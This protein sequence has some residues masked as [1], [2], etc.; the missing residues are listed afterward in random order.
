[1]TGFSP[2]FE[3]DSILGFKAHSQSDLQAAKPIAKVL[4][5]AKV[6]EEEKLETSKNESSW[7]E[8]GHPLGDEVGGKSISDLGLS[9]LLRFGG[10]GPFGG[11]LK[12]RVDVD[13]IGPDPL[14]FMS[15]FLEELV[16]DDELLGQWGLEKSE[17]ERLSSG[18]EGSKEIAERL[19]KIK[20]A[21]E[22]NRPEAIA[23]FSEELKDQL[24]IKGVVYFPVLDEE[25]KYTQVV[26]VDKEHGFSVIEVDAKHSPYLTEA[27]QL[28]QLSD[29]GKRQQLIKQTSIDPI[30]GKKTEVFKVQQFMSF[31][32]R[33][34][35][36]LGDKEFFAELVKNSVLESENTREMIYTSLP[37]YVDGKQLKASDTE[38]AFYRK[39]YRYFDKDEK[40]TSFQC[41]SALLYYM[42]L[43]PFF[44]SE[45]DCEKAVKQYKTIKFLLQSQ[46]FFAYV[47]KIED[48]EKWNKVSVE[49]RAFLNDLLSNLTRSAEKLLRT[50]AI[51]KEQ[52]NQFFISGQHV[53]DVL[54]SPI[55]AQGI[56][57]FEEQEVLARGEVLSSLTARFDD[58]ETV[59]AI[60]IPP[61]A[62]VGH[63]AGGLHMPAAQDAVDEKTPAQ[64]LIRELTEFDYTL[65]LT[66]ESEDKDKVID[67]LNEN[68]E[69]LTEQYK[70]L[71]ANPR[72]SHTKS[73]FHFAQ[74]A[75]ESERRAVFDQFNRTLG[76]VVAMLP[77]PE[78]G[79]NGFWGKLTPDQA[80]KCFEVVEGFSLLVQSFATLER[81][82][83]PFARHES[84]S[85]H[86][87]ETT[88][89]M[90]T[91]QAVQ[92]KLAS[93]DPRFALEEGKFSFLPYLIEMRSIGFVVEHPG[94]R[95]QVHSLMRY[96]NPKWN[97]EELTRPLK[98][99][100]LTEDI[101][102]LFSFSHKRE[103]NAS[104]WEISLTND[105]KEKSLDQLYFEKMLEASDVRDGVRE[106]MTEKNAEY[107]RQH[108][109]AVERYE[110]ELRQ[111]KDEKARLNELIEE[112]KIEIDT[113]K[114]RHDPLINNIAQERDRQRLRDLYSVNAQIRNAHYWDDTT[115]LKARKAQ[116]LQNLS[117]IPNAED[118]AE[119]LHQAEEAKRYEL[120][121]P[122]RRLND[123]QFD[124]NRLA[125]PNE[126]VHPGN[127]PLDSVV[128]Q[129]SCLLF[130]EEGRRL[131]PKEMNALVQAMMRNRYLILNDTVNFDLDG[132]EIGF[133]FTGGWQP[134]P[135]DAQNKRGSITCS[136]E[137]LELDRG[138]RSEIR[139]DFLYDCS[140]Y[141]IGNLR[142]RPAFRDNDWRLEDDYQTLIRIESDRELTQNQAMISRESLFGL[143]VSLTKEL[144]MLAI[145]PYDVVSR[146]VGFLR[147]NMELI[148]NP[149]IQ[150]YVHVLLFRP[151]RIHTQLRDNP[152][153]T[154]KIDAFIRAA[155]THYKELHD[156]DTCLAMI[157]LG[158]QFRQAAVEIN[159]NSSGFSDYRKVVLK[160]LIPSFSS[161]KATD[162][163]AQLKAYRTLFLLHAYDKSSSD[164]D[165]KQISKIVS[166]LLALRVC[167]NL[168]SE[169]AMVSREDESLEK[170]ALLRFQ[171]LLEKEIS[172]QDLTNA[173]KVAVPDAGLDDSSEWIDNGDGT[174]TCGMFEINVN[175]GLVKNDG[176]DVVTTPDWI[177]DNEMLRR[178]YPHSFT[179]STCQKVN[180]WT[181]VLFP[182]EEDKQV[183]VTSN[184]YGRTVQI[185]RL[186]G[187]KAYRFV[188]TPEN[189][190]EYMPTLFSRDVLCWVDDRSEMLVYKDN[191]KAY[192]V[193]YEQI[194]AYQVRVEAL[195]RLSDLATHVS[196]LDGPLSQYFMPL[197]S[198]EKDPK[199]IECWQSRDGKKITV[200]F[201]RLGLSFDIKP[202]EIEK[203][204]LSRD[205][206]LKT[207]RMAELERLI[208]ET[209]E[210]DEVRAYQIEHTRLR[211]ELA[212]MFPVHCQN[213]PGFSL[214]MPILT[215]SL[216]QNVPYITLINGSGER[217]ILVPKTENQSERVVEQPMEWYEYDVV[218][219]KSNGATSFDIK[220]SSVEL[221][222]LQLTMLANRRD[223]KKVKEILDKLNPLGALTENE[224]RL[225]E[226]AAGILGSYNHPEANALVVK[227]LLVREVNSLK[228]PQ[229]RLAEEEAE[230]E[231][232][233]DNLEEFFRE[234]LLF[235]GA[236]ER[237][238]ANTGDLAAFRLTDEEERKFVELLHT[239]LKVKF[240]KLKNISNREVDGAGVLQ[241]IGAKAQQW[242][243][244]QMLPTLVAGFLEEK[245][246]DRFHDLS[247]QEGKLGF[248]KVT[249]ASIPRMDQLQGKGA[250]PTP[251]EEEILRP[252][253]EILGEDGTR[254][255]IP[256]ARTIDKCLGV[257]VKDEAYWKQ[258]FV[259]LY[260]VARSGTDDEKSR[261]Q[262]ALDLATHLNSGEHRILRWVMDKPGRYKS[263]EQLNEIIHQWRETALKELHD[264][265]VDFDVK[266][267]TLDRAQQD[268][269]LKKQRYEDIKSDEG[270]ILDGAEFCREASRS[271]GL[272]ERIG[273]LFRYLVSRPTKSRRE[274]Y[275]L[276]ER[277]RVLNKCKKLAE[278][279]KRTAENHL[280]NGDD[281]WMANWYRSDVAK[282][283]R[284]I[285]DIERR[286]EGIREISPE[287]ER[288]KNEL[289]TS[290]KA[291]SKAESE[292]V[293]ANKRREKAAR[294]VESMEE[295][296]K[297]SI[298]SVL[299]GKLWK[300]INNFVKPIF[301]AIG[302]VWKYFW[303]GKK[304]LNSH[305]YKVR[306]IFSSGLIT[307]TK[308]PLK[309]NRDELCAVDQSFN[310]YFQELADHFFDVT[311]TDEGEDPVWNATDGGD[312]L[313]K[314]KLDAEKNALNEYRED[315]RKVREHADLKEDADI[316]DLLEELVEK[317][318]TLKA[319]LVHQKE[320]LLW[321]LNRAINSNEQAK[322]T[323]SMNRIGMKGDL[324]WD[325]LRALSL[326]GDLVDFQ[327]KTGLDETNAKMLMKGVADYLVKATRLNQIR[328][329]I[330]KV[331][332]A[333]AA[334]TEDK[335]KIYYTNILEALKLERH[336]L[337]DS[338][339]TLS[340]K[341]MGR[342]WFE[343]SNG[344]LY[345]E[346]QIK[347]L[348]ETG[349]MTDPEIL[350]EAPTGFGKSKNY[351][352]TRDHEMAGEHLVLNVH[353]R[354]IEQIN[355]E[356]ILAQMRDSFGG[357]ADRFHFQRSTQFTVH[358]LKALYED[359]QVNFE[360]GR[361][362]NFSAETL[363]AL[364]LHFLMYLYDYK[365][366]EKSGTF[367]E[368]E[369]TEARQEIAYFIMIL[370]AVS[371]YGWATIDESHVNLNPFTNKLIY[372]IGES[373]TL[374]TYQVDILEEMMRLMVDDTEIRRIAKVE[375]NKQ[376]KV[377]GD[378]Y[379]VIARKLGNHFADK[380]RIEEDKKDEYLQFVLGNLDE[381]PGWIQKHSQAKQIALVKG[382]LS[383]ILK[384]SM[385]GYVDETYGLSKLHFDKGKEYAIAY[386]SSNTPK[387]NETSPSQFKNPHETMAKTYLT[388]LHKGLREEQVVKMIKKMQA[389]QLL[390]AQTTGS[391]SD[392][393]ANKAFREIAGEEYS[394]QQLNEEDMHRLFPAFQHNADAIF[395]YVRNI[396][397]PQLRLYEKTLVSTP[398]NLRS[399]FGSSLSL[400]A[401]PQDPATHGP[402]TVMVPMKGTQG[403]VTHLFLKK[404]DRSEKIHKAKGSDPEEVME[405]AIDTV[406]INGHIKCIID[407][408][409]LMR[410]L[411]N[412]KVA[413]RLRERILESDSSIEAV[414]YFD[415]VKE[416]F[417]VMEVSTGTLSD[418]HVVKT[419]PAKMVTIFDQPRCFGSDTVQDET[420]SALLLVNNSKT[421]SCNTDKNKAGQG[422][423][424][425]RQWHL[426]QGMEVMMTP[427]DHHSLFGDKEAN[428]GDLLNEWVGSLAKQEAKENYQALLQQMDNELRSPAMHRMLGVK[429]GD[430]EKAQK[431]TIRDVVPDVDKALR[432]FGK[433]ESLLVTDDSTD[434]W[435]LYA[436]MPK[437][438]KPEECLD[439]HLKRTKAKA[440]KMGGFSSS[441]RKILSSRLGR[442]SK[443][444]EK[445]E[446]GA[447]D[448]RVKLPELVQS[449][450]VDTGNQV[451]VQVQAEQEVEAHVQEQRIDHLK[452]RTPSKW[453]DRISLFDSGW[454]KPRSKSVFFNRLAN[455]ISKLEP[456]KPILKVA[457]RIGL[458]AAGTAL[459]ATVA[460]VA[461]VAWPI[462]VGVGSA[463]L[464]VGSFYAVYKM[465]ARRNVKYMP[466]CSYKVSEVM[467][468]HLPKRAKRAARFF[469]P[470]LTVS[471]NYYA[472]NTPSWRESVQKPFNQEQK[473]VFNVLVIQ[474]KDAEGKKKLQMMMI[475]QNDSVYF[476]RRLQA[477]YEQAGQEDAEKR[478]RKIAVY[479]VVNGVISVEGAN[480][481][482]ERELEDNPEF[483]SLLMQ[484]KVINGEIHYT[485]EEKAALGKRA[486]QV[487]VAQMTRFAE[488]YALA[489][490]PIQKLLFPDS[491]FNHALQ[492]VMV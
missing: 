230:E 281:D 188:P 58:A 478:T 102:S 272:F 193:A 398:Q 315:V 408:G 212:E 347:T 407:A 41:V 331:H 142:A 168:Q 283:E 154:E 211:L 31:E 465:F 132:Q 313:V 47:N 269:G 153:L 461:G 49:E 33:N 361:P 77:A 455:S 52:A 332:K 43:D 403:Q 460:A 2:R 267:E 14:T 97:V 165:E 351:I 312:P 430:K 450:K 425:M 485:E 296:F 205:S 471:N 249:M 323:M 195:T 489:E 197:A 381:I 319:S 330:G 405:S 226:R 178:V 382:M 379:A 358:T 391:F 412:E 236:Y 106:I 260:H 426:D 486:Q 140:D 185:V 402:D 90:L 341:E 98:D 66:E 95:K 63:F 447:V 466:N 187:G 127:Y 53:K 284:S 220:S 483:V 203:V 29:Q 80:K 164:L 10:G 470:N 375:E 117:P 7:M 367:T 27:D 433:F 451:E 109:A 431:D 259:T 17:L 124:L 78:R 440:K 70:Q 196:F 73:F 369:R 476:R 113:V 393:R 224:K 62:A 256:D 438:R 79:D 396:I 21:E 123:C 177:T 469:S 395:Y 252:F 157:R 244:N 91:L 310:R 192:K 176:T 292:V 291:H 246:G 251:T 158:E 362:I 321:Q 409:G 275:R 253:L 462:I 6:E 57:S 372:T 88:V 247:T 285:V 255:E 183:R 173:V 44:G 219:V 434:P 100:D 76:D 250:K 387:E 258:H 484:A 354:T 463:L 468:I 327:E 93:Q 229:I 75:S 217:K 342:L 436:E 491:D 376:A 304:F 352:P 20:E 448:E 336:Y 143:S 125:E 34:K 207:D 38:S 26:R 146:T 141:R 182:G 265:E 101:Q 32:A 325:D 337:K 72:L 107:D 394:L 115:D 120:E 385:Q 421:G 24:E 388:Y 67:Q 128:D 135:L 442:Y 290:Q 103:Y 163:S 238:R 209:E 147:R 377:T 111:Y 56:K 373:T 322:L 122:Q 119:R 355:A 432:L 16:K 257:L 482:E 204:T 9:G 359:L 479:D 118:V 441:Q 1:M 105:K 169:G 42:S 287:L 360:E 114:R 51:K 82:Y 274:S 263:I 218:K 170:A 475:D 110:R 262:K 443:K 270:K 268:L 22:G 216:D 89:M 155:V 363:Q 214:S 48:E 350:M 492:A 390:E 467:G 299:P 273:K 458:V 5:E 457:F 130:T 172:D 348:D 12:G 223:F 83:K 277:I 69:R 280:K 417:V 383:I 84:D 480:E 64:S 11:V 175:T 46:L 234:D 228:Y 201:K 297:S 416:K 18:L 171:H 261:L 28:D 4:Y 345:R 23:A 429:T 194:D 320:V 472:Q 133:Q 474:D 139:S 131:I 374:E 305:T 45:K 445:P 241:K 339:A 71:K 301:S 86:S 213:F 19:A 150:E 54:S 357:K 307:K 180:E 221:Q 356:D 365:T 427:E 222:L 148:K 302:T 266:Q 386:A 37:K 96:F 366:K 254:I 166:D 276:G 422:A 156:M 145:D 162:K 308:T 400:S 449:S 316:G 279:A 300:V 477:D 50:N 200:D 215:Q 317:E 202:E 208:E 186:I 444:W 85:G 294:H 414:Q 368:K 437:D 340:R 184:D 464:V 25:G 39:V 36:R 490:H 344:Y 181:Y 413:S 419:D 384:S 15:G 108:E 392:T 227:M 161:N 233:P 399:M 424:R 94:L 370:R 420:A 235:I 61:K 311:K 74:P 55:M 225:M 134:L 3:I 278:K 454:E 174:Y 104:T 245:I 423:G 371:V 488:D 481:F 282:M 40:D 328:F 439:E 346:Q 92:L 456:K 151:D 401:T 121:G 410:G 293:E 286:I 149:A 329:V 59:D 167:K 240:D 179:S 306:D 411:S 112:Y 324:S 191:Q 242:F 309:V 243:K 248:R 435:T 237:Y 199:F 159:G 81:S 452:I 138:R 129:L 389:E 35:E 335:R 349:A 338:G 160:E 473:P 288:A 487:G 353:P 446:T 206:L 116:I 232:I 210:E 415:V 289:K 60:A 271:G 378:N 68:L 189:M 126:P 137:T 404:V 406:L 397:V 190:I 65:E 298:T 30:T 380:Y 314:A 264:A 343:F 136:V 295:K 334:K 198:L 453:S 13:P 8:I 333:Q 152:E 459:A 326:S 318:G 428:I 99:S 239:K 364:E 87:P 418:P 303:K 231:E 144:R